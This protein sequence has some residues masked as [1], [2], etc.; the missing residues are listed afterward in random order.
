LSEDETGVNCTMPAISWN[1]RGPLSASPA[2]ATG[3]LS[4]TTTSADWFG[5]T[6]TEVLLKL[7]ECALPAALAWATLKLAAVEP[8]LISLMACLPL[9]SLASSW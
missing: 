5:G 3:T 1:D 2:V 6:V 8:L 4:M 9:K 7:T